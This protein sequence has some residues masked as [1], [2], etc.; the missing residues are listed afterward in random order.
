MVNA[1][2]AKDS[3]LLG[4]IRLLMAAIKQCEIDKRTDGQRFLLDDLGIVSVVEKLIKQRNESIEQFKAGN[5]PDLVSKEEAEIR[6]L[7]NYLPPQL[8]EQE[9]DEL[10]SQALKE[11]GAISMKDM[12]KVMAI[13]KNSLQ[14]RA[15]ISAVSAKVKAHLVNA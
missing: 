5:R 10:I 11:S 9:T 3:E 4:T 15:D 14:G 12:G 13:L 1:M 2:R 8:T 7:Q 6:I